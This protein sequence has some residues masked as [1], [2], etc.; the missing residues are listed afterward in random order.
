VTFPCEKRKDFSEIFQNG[1]KCIDIVMGDLPL[2]SFLRQ[3]PINVFL[4]DFFFSFFLMQLIYFG[5][6]PNKI[7]IFLFFD[8]LQ[9]Q[10]EEEI[11]H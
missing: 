6:K 10:G 1:E 9:N 3:K 8:M 2:F 5:Q 11:G 7:T 4:N